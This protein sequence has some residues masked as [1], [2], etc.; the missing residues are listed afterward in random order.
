M[1]CDI[2]YASFVKEFNI[3]YIPSALRLSRD[4]LARNTRLWSKNKSFS[5]GPE[6]ERCA[7]LI[8]AHKQ[9]LRAEGFKV[10]HL[11][12]HDSLALQEQLLLY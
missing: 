7:K 2:R 8:E 12:K 10:G 3:S 6:S 1:R 9:C 11:L 4:L 5:A